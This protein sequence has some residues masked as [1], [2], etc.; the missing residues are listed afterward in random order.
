MSAAE[1]AGPH[2]YH[3]TMVTGEARSD[4]RTRRG[5]VGVLLFCFSQGQPLT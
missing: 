5:L 2:A 1:G 3:T 4:E